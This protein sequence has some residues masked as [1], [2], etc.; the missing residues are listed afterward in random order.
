M[1]ISEETIEKFKE[2]EQVARNNYRIEE[3]SDDHRPELNALTRMQAL[4][5]L[6][7]TIYI[8]LQRS[9]NN[10]LA[11]F[12]RRNGKIVT[13]IDAFTHATP[14]DENEDVRTARLLARAL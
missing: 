13:V 8:V 11:S 5:K 1:R 2:Q 12:F 9:N 14:I 10:L 6:Y 7:K 4:H 3:G